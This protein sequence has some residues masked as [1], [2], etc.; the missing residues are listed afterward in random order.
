M[1]DKTSTSVN[2]KIIRE[3]ANLIVFGNFIIPRKDCLK[4]KQY[5]ENLRNN[6]WIKRGVLEIGKSCGGLE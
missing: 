3:G 4:C 1:L 6:A 2:E 5:Y